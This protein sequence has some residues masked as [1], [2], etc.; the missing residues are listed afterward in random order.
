MIPLLLTASL[1]VMLLSG[2]KHGLL[3]GGA[4][5][6]QA[7]LLDLRRELSLRSYAQMVE[8]GT[9]AFDV[10]YKQA[11]LTLATGTEAQAQVALEVVRHQART[12]AGEWDLRWRMWG[13][14]AALLDVA[15][16]CPPLR[17]RELRLPSLRALACV[18]AAAVPMLPPCLGL[19]LHVRLLRLG[20][21][22][23]LRILL[24]AHARRCLPDAGA[25]L[26]TLARASVPAY[27][28]LLLAP[29]TPNRVAPVA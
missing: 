13:D 29:A 16:P 26:S 20:V 4:K 15:A 11:G 1:A 3:L 22:L 25:D 19:R 5:R 24:H 8:I 7:L 14:A 27:E 28:A 18:D 12:L 23:S 6:G 2:I 17:A 10:A 9:R 21:A